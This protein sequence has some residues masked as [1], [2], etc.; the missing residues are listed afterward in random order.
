MD[1]WAHSSWRG[2]GGGEVEG[3]RAEARPRLRLGFGVDVEVAGVWGGLC[4][5]GRD[6]GGAGLRPAGDAGVVVAV[7][8]RAAGTL[9]DL[10]TFHGS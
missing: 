1:G 2:S 10:L 4:F 7:L 3:D 8:E 5:V 6:V 9:S